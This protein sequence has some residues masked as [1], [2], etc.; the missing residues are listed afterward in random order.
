MAQRI[1]SPK[2]APVGTRNEAKIKWQRI[3]FP[4]RGLAGITSIEFSHL[5]EVDDIVL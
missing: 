3:D 5:L 4:P 1:F 2:Q